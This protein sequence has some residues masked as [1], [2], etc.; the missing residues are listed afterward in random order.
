MKYIYIQMYTHKH[1]VQ[2][3]PLLSAVKKIL[4]IRKSKEKEKNKRTDD[5]EEEEETYHKC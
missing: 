3:V 1:I 2:C 4:Y 5:D